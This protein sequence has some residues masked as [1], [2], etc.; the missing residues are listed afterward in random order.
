MPRTR[1][2]ALLGALFVVLCAL[3]LLQADTIPTSLA[4][5]DVEEPPAYLEATSG[6]GNSDL[7]I[8]YISAS[9]SSADAG[10]SKQV[11][12]RI[13]NQG[14][15]SSGSFYW[16][17][18]LSTDTTITTNDIE[19]DN[20]YKSSMS[21]GSTTST[22][23]K[24]VTIPMSING[25]RYYVGA[26]ADINTQVSESNENNNDDYDSGR[27]TIYEAPDLTG[28]SCSA[29][30]TGVVGD[31]LDS[32]ISIS[33]ENDPGGSYIDSSGT[34]YWAMYLS[35]DS[36]ITSSDDQVGSDQYRSSIS[37]GSYGTDTLSTSTRIP[38]NLNPGTY[39]WGFIIDVRTD[40][41]E[42]SET[43]NV[44]LCSSQVVIEDDL[45]D[46]FADDVGTSYS[47][48]IM[49]DTISV[50][51]RIENIGHD[52]TGSFYWKLYLSTDRTIT[53]S[54]TF[55]DEF[56][57]SSISSGSYSSGTEY[58]VTI[59]TGM[60]PGYY[61]LGMI[62]DNRGQVTE[63]DETN[64]VVADSG[65]ID[66]E[67][68]ADLVPQSPSGPTSAYTGDS[69][70]LGWR[71]NNE[72]DDSSGWFYWKA[73]LSTDSTITSSDTLLGSSNYASS[74]SGNSY[75]YGNLQVTIPSSL[76][77]GT[78]YWGIIADTT[79][80]VAEGDET[81]NEES[82][83]SV[84]ITV[85]EPDLRADLISITQ[86]TRTICE[87][88][89]MNLNV[90]VSNQGN[91]NAGSHYYEVL[92]SQSG[93]SGSW[94]SIGQASG[95]SGVSSYSTQVGGTATSTMGVGSYYVR[96]FVDS[97]YQ[98]S[99]SDESNNIYTSTS[100]ELTIQDCRPDLT[101]T[102]LN[103][104]TS[105]IAGQSI[106]L[107]YTVENSGVDTANNIAVDMFLSTDRTITTSDSH[108]GATSVGIAG[109]SSHSDTLSVSIP[110]NLGS[111]CWYYG[112]IVDMNDVIPELNENDNSFSPAG[113]VCILQPN[114][115]VVSVSSPG[116]ST[117]GQ[118]VEVS[119]L[120]ENAGGADAGGHT[121]SIFIEVV[122][123][124]GVSETL[125]ESTII[126]NLVS[127]STLEVTRT[128]QLPTSPS[129]TFRIMVVIDY[130]AEITESDE[131]DN[132]AFGAS[133]S[134]TSPTNDLLA[135]WITGPTAAEP[136]QTITLQWQVENLGSEE[137]AFDVEVWL[138]HDA[139]LDS[140]DWKVSTVSIDNLDGGTST[141]E[142]TSIQLTEA[143]NGTWWLILFVDSANNHDEDDENNNIISSANSL[144]VSFDAPDPIDE[145][146]DGCTIPT[147]DGNSS[148]D[149]AN[150]RASAMQLG[151]DVESITIQGCLIDSDYDDW[152]GVMLHGGKRLGVSL[153]GENVEFSISLM[154]G[155]V[156]EDSGSITP[157]ANRINV[158]LTNL[159]DVNFSRVYHIK[160]SRNFST[161][162]GAYTLRI[163]TVD[164]TEVPDL[165]PPETPE[166][167]P[168][169]EW[170]SGTE[171]E[172]TWDDVEDSGDAGLSHYQVRWTGSLW[173]DVEQN[174]TTLNISMLT[175]G[176]HSLEIRALDTVG[177]PSPAS[178]IWVRIDRTAPFIE[179][180]Q[181]GAQYAGPPVLNVAM[182]FND[183]QGSG[184]A[185]VQWSWDN[186]TW[187]IMPPGGAII[188]SNWSDT[189]FYLRATD[190]VGLTTIVNFTIDP[191]TNPTAPP[192]GAQDN[193]AEGTGGPSTSGVAATVLIALML[194]GLAAAGLYLAFRSRALD[195]EEEDFE[196]DEED[197]ANEPVGDE[198]TEGTQSPPEPTS[199]V[200]EGTADQPTAL[201]LEG[202]AS[203]VEPVRVENHEGL[204]PGGTYDQSTGVTW[205]L[206]PDGSRWWQD[207]DGSFAL[208]V[209]GP[210][211]PDKP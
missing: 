118:S 9:W 19:L 69:V 138:S 146:N 18:Y 78:Y 95:S 163:V 74:I 89:T 140:A 166:F 63:L 151:V 179:A 197:V 51:Y 128:I 104:P 73:Y 71:I 158:R 75:R 137:R 82:G 13:E 176:R 139:G 131:T 195:K 200:L 96:L 41:D 112:V 109:G 58:S 169:E 178:A 203:T 45:P 49:G 116:P 27:V 102:A 107:S 207:D 156:A 1:H 148:S 152:F 79:D 37:G 56:S 149:A 26:L 40:V 33:I 171:I 110:S 4:T 65:R 117:L 25:A 86:S 57:R 119:T 122:E 143:D 14:T 31:N 120:V 60:N 2:A 162:G 98:I 39:Y 130:L 123:P 126:S 88:G 192:T 23:Y 142:Q 59:P 134:V 154:N 155:S 190:N 191:P 7:I 181:I 38:S 72:G 114:L 165:N 101:P 153:E 186:E 3:S 90:D 84:S 80:Y 67:E 168:L 22:Y 83:N 77:G 188:W 111:G 21:A 52:Y 135:N 76:S 182:N 11:S 16:G 34:F 133:F 99:E 184:I 48:G 189:D 29:P 5:P 28:R 6:R 43:N 210:I 15:D 66:I 204:S 177:N 172:V 160:I 159:D 92:F 174:S 81:N 157:E 55:V 161:I 87:Q 175:D 170:L 20:Y 17:I 113:Q 100:R 93:T 208:D 36:T 47:S 46:V 209:S 68:P 202:T 8:D 50:T 115:R 147:T 144:L 198:V 127:G 129:G 185:N 44:Y 187:S 194:A 183:G 124:T 121:L 30:T 199:P 64:N 205:Y 42:Q 10:D 180:E 145:T 70:S 193:E 201:Q 53:T 97:S 132:T 206:A 62:A 106:S 32:T 103:G 196:N 141:T 12:V 35:T 150:S 211:P 125:V 61:Y 167:D 85:A 173:A 136:G 54:D 105:I 24:S 94:T 164:S 91:T 108:L